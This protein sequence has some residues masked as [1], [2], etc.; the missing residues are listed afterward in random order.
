MKQLI[1]GM[2]FIALCLSFGACQKDTECQEVEVVRNC[3]GTYLRFMDKEYKVCNLDMVANYA[4]GTKITASFT[5]QDNCPAWE[6]SVTCM[7]L[8]ESEGWIEVKSVH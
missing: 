8:Y 1:I 4:E 3:T 2:G 7:M 6:N 5:H